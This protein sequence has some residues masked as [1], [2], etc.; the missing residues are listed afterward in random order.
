M[1]TYYIDF[2]NG[3]DE[4]DGRSPETPFKTQH[5]E[6]LKPDDTV[7][8]RRGTMFRGPLQNPSG[9]SEHPIHYGA[10]GDGEPP[11]FCGSQNLSDPAEWE[12]I[13]G[14]I[15]EYTGA[16]SGE[17]A[18]LI[19]GDG[20]CGAMRWTKEELREQGDWFDSCFGYTKEDIALP[21][22][23]CLLV[24]SAENPAAFY[25]AICS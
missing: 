17:T 4:N 23:H 19:Y 8:F 24:W 12:H 6:L 22:N 13:G 16:L 2:Q 14:S 20:T 9:Y 11:V 1:T 5:P 3:C 18:N 25:T 10:Y 7:L 21:E 15:W